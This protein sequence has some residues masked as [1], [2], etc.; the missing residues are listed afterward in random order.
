MAGAM[1]VKIC[2]LT[3]RPA[4]DAVIGRGASHVGFVHFAPSPRHLALDAMPELRAHVGAR[5][6]VVVVVVDPDDALVEARA[7]TV[8]PDVLQLH[9]GESPAR[10]RAWRERFGIRTMKAVAV[11]GPADIDRAH[12]FVGV[13]D[14]LLLDAKRPK[15]SDLPGGNGRA[16][17]WSLLARLDRGVRYM[18]S[19]GIDAG[20]VGQAL[21]LARPAGLDVSSGVE[22]RPGVKDLGRIHG[23]FDALDALALDQERQTA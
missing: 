6:G 3:T 2:G 20:N 8:R 11:G 21:R 14:Q 18:L 10:V 23:F 9:G 5:A 15:G 19:G 12:S 16:F 22:V 17:D 13:A 1:D 4:I 7:A